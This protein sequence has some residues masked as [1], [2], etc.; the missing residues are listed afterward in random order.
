AEALTEF[1]LKKILMEKMQRSQSYRTAD[2]HNCLYEDLVISYQLDKD[3]FD[4]YG[5]TISLKRSREDDQDQDPSAEP[6]QVLLNLV[7]LYRQ[8][9]QYKKQI[10]HDVQMDVGTTTSTDMTKAA[11]VLPIDPK[12][13]RT[14]PDWYPRSE[15]PDPAWNTVKTI[16]DAGEQP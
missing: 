7:N 11:D 14:R 12:P 15:I 16:D 1:E 9:N 2:E 3:L 8:E 5:Q 10:M 6:D 13:K 4:S